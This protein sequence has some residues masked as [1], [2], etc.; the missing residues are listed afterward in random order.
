[1]R[2]IIFTLAVMLASC[3]TI[4]IDTNNTFKLLTDSGDTI[5]CSVGLK[6]LDGVILDTKCLGYFEKDGSTYECSLDIGSD[7]K[8]ITEV[9]DIKESCIIVI[10]K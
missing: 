6:N 7:G 1:M 2:F 5:S 8:P 3:A 9:V 4:Q 10:K